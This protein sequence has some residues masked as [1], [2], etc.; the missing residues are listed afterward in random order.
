MPANEFSKKRRPRGRQAPPAELAATLVR[1]GARR[2]VNIGPSSARRLAAQGQ[3]RAMRTVDDVCTIIQTARSEGK[4]LDFGGGLRRLNEAGGDVQQAIDRLRFGHTEMHPGVQKVSRYAAERGIELTAW[5]IRFYVRHRGEEGARA[6]IA[7]LANI[8]DAAAVLGEECSLGTALWRLSDAD[9]DSGLAVERLVSRHQRTMA[10]WGKR[11]E[12]AVTPRDQHEAAKARATCA[13]RR[14]LDALA[15][16]L[17]NYIGV[18]IRNDAAIRI[19]DPDEARGAA[20]EALMRAVETW[21]GGRSFTGW[22]SGVF[23]RHVG[24]IHSR[25]AHEE[26]SMLSLDQPIGGDRLGNPVTI[27]DLVPDRTVDP[28]TIVV[29]RETLRERFGEIR[30]EREA[31][32]D[33]YDVF[34]AQAA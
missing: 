6:H 23:R 32:S 29:W 14:C 2:G 20:S 27:G 7:G 21:P 19:L 28:A 33:E 11:C 31:R 34:G 22:F 30:A 1:R 9:G 25:R 10:R 18:M 3:A 16:Q 24:H 15:R 17:E 13:C 26:W 8:M 5:T 12:V 4:R